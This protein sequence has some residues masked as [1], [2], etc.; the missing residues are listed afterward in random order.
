LPIALGILAASGQIPLESLNRYEFAGELAVT[1]DLRPIGGALAMTYQ[2]T[3]KLEKASSDLP[4]IGEKPSNKSVIK[5]KREFI[6]PQ[7]SAAEA[8]L[9]SDAIIFP[10]NSLL[11]VCA[12]L[13]GHTALQPY[14]PR[15]H[16]AQAIYANFS[17]VKV[18]SLPKRALEIAAAGGHSVLMSGPPRKAKSML[19]ARFSGIL[20]AMSD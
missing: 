15:P 10:A 20:P 16:V 17:E 12:H 4:K 6:L 19:A 3:Y 14:K 1:G 7:N 5:I 2:M 9:V 8:A 18:Q 11:E 13:A